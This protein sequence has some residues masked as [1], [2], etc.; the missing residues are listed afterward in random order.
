[1]TD[2]ATAEVPGPAGTGTSRPGRLQV[3]ERIP[4]LA[5]RTHHGEEL[6]LDALAGA[7]AWVMFFPFAFSRV[8]GAELASVQAARQDV[9]E[10]GARVVAISCDSVHT[11][12]AYAEHLAAGAAE[13]AVDLLSDFWP[14]GAISRACG[15]FDEARGAPT[16]TSYI[17]DAQARV[18]HVQNVPSHE[19]RDV[20]EA[21]AALRH[22]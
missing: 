13:P 16:R 8:C 1:M 17:L 7:P 15:V 12:R 14:H 6:R 11:L 21:L 2:P 3:G 20:E 18:R 10:M 9:A 22:S 19:S 4:A 5:G